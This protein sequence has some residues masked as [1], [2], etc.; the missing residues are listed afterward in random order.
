MFQPLLAF[1]GHTA[2]LPPPTQNT[3]PDKCKHQTQ[4]HE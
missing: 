4:Q 3:P 2:H 1:K